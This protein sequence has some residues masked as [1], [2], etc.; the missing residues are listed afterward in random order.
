[1]KKSN[2]FFS[3]IVDNGKDISIDYAEYLSYK[4]MKRT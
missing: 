1:M 4:I 3:V 2:G